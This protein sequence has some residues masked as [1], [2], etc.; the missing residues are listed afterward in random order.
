[1]A[2]CD[3]V[4]PKP[5]GGGPAVFLAV[6]GPLLCPLLFDIGLFGLGS[7]LGSSAPPPLPSQASGVSTLQGL[8]GQPGLWGSQSPLPLAPV[9]VHTHPSGSAFQPPPGSVPKGTHLGPVGE[10]PGTRKRALGSG[11]R[12]LHLLGV[13]GRVGGPLCLVYPLQVW[14]SPSSP[15]PGPAWSFTRLLIKGTGMRQQ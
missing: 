8:R 9:T 11:P 5:Q 2:L 3:Q 15:W 12:P 4:K 1:M 10:H 13:G 7:E 14:P 6:R